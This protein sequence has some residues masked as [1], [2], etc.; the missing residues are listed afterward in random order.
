MALTK[1]FE[2]LNGFDRFASVSLFLFGFIRVYFSQL[3][4][5]LSLRL[6][7]PTFTRGCPLSS[8]TYVRRA[9][10]VGPCITL[11]VPNVYPTSIAHGA[12]RPAY[13]V[14]HGSSSRF[15][16][17]ISLMDWVRPLVH[18]P[19][20]LPTFLLLTTPFKDVSRVPTQP[21]E[22]TPSPRQLFFHVSR[23][24]QQHIRWGGV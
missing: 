21:L 16:R 20:S 22:S 18:I 13:R 1:Q 8:V 7:D 11:V 2:H 12:D 24:S 10:R 6:P 4:R 19:S 15:Y 5:K 17:H 14:Y 3:R 23:S 9:E